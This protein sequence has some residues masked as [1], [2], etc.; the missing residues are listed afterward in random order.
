MKH[1]IHGN[2]FAYVAILMTGVIFLVL[3]SLLGPYFVPLP[4]PLICTPYPLSAPLICYFTLYPQIRDKGACV[5]P[6]CYFEP[7]VLYADST[8]CAWRCDRGRVVAISPKL[9]FWT[10]TFGKGYLAISDHPLTVMLIPT[11]FG[12]EHVQ[13]GVWRWPGRT[14]WHNIQGSFSLLNLH[15]CLW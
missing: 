8:I 12:I 11:W 3:L 1:W 13:H 9:L 4:I 2:C 14:A 7:A 10:H 15:K 5:F 6:K